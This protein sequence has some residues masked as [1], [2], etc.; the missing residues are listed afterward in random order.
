MAKTGFHGLNYESFDRKRA[1]GEETEG[2]NRTKRKLQGL[3][4]KT[5]ASGQWVLFCKSVGF[6]TE[7]TGIICKYF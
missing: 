6:K 4:G 7:E 5:G 3:K 2:K 1:L